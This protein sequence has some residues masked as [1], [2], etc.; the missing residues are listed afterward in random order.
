MAT[1]N[2][3]FAEIVRAYM[4]AGKTKTEAVAAAVESNP[5]EYREYLANGGGNI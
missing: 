2:K 4:A 5:D 3:T 1:E